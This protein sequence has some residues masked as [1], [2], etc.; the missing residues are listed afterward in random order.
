MCVRKP[1]TVSTE[2]LL[3]T[4]AFRWEGATK[5]ATH[6]IGVMPGEIIRVGSMEK[7]SMSNARGGTFSQGHSVVFD[8]EKR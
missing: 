8:V 4:F 2:L 5:N 3:V 7:H 6:W 1:Y